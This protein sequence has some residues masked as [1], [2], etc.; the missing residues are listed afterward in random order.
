MITE[1]SRRRS[2]PVFPPMSNKGRSICIRPSKKSPPKHRQIRKTTRVLRARMP[3]KI[4][5]DILPAH[6]RSKVASYISGGHQTD[7]ALS[8]ARTNHIQRQAV[9]STL[10]HKLCLSLFNRNGA[11]W[12]EVFGD[13]IQTLVVEDDYKGLF[14]LG[15]HPDPFTF[16]AAPSLRRAEILDE[17]AVLR[18]IS[19]S[20]SLRDLKVTIYGIAPQ[21]SLVGTLSRLALSSLELVCAHFVQNT[22]PFNNNRSQRNSLPELLMN[23]SQTLS[24]LR[25]SC[26]YHATCQTSLWKTIPHLPQLREVAISADPPR[27]ALVHLRSIQAVRICSAPH[28]FQLA[29][30][31]RLK[32]TCLESSE[33]LHANQIASLIV[34]PRLALLGADVDEGAEHSLQT[35]FRG[36]EVL[37]SLKLRWPQPHQASSQLYQTTALTLAEANSDVILGAIPHA[38]VLDELY[39]LNVRLRKEHMKGVLSILGGRLKH[40]GISI[41]GQVDP[42]L[43]YLECMIR[44]LATHNSQLRT[45][46]VSEVASFEKHLMRESYRRATSVQE[47]E[48]QLYQLRC[49]LCALKRSAPLVQTCKLEMFICFLHDTPAQALSG[50][51]HPELD[52]PGIIEYAHDDFLPLSQ[53]DIQ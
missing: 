23:H 30:M 37:H 28:G 13:E 44:I 32:V 5:F 15:S 51:E 52:V 12:M 7:A 6:I 21:E 10:S 33:R 8:F 53:S 14:R 39:F 43:F 26:L 36:V 9:L 2:I 16:M 29:M 38:P 1:C 34:C 19:M 24:A 20:T 4:W 50:Y 31:L 40:L 22:C 42:P 27:N 45:F 18:A 35:L 41:W 17:P 11:Q 48:S 25:L 49:A 3:R 47:R 46:Y